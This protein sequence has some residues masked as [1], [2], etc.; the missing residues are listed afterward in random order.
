MDQFKIPEFVRYLSCGYFA[1]A[2]AYFCEPD[3]IGELLSKTGQIGTS[4]VAFILGL[5][6]FHLYRSAIQ[7]YVLFPLKD[8]Y[9]KW[10][11][12]QNLRIYLQGVLPNAQEL[13]PIEIEL[14]WYVIRDKAQLPQS[15]GEG[16]R[17]EASGIHF[18]YISGL[19]CILGCLYGLW[20][21][22]VSDRNYQVPYWLW[23]YPRMVGAG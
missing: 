18:L 6:I 19:I 7:H 22:V 3:S 16:M 13:K 15:L 12:T 21:V 11:N 4:I 23:T 2:I 8:H 9:C 20:I 10:R 1:V 14:Q 17:R 5:L